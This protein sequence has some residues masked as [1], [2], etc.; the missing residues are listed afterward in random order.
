[1][2]YLQHRGVGTNLVFARS[3][4][5]IPIPRPAFDQRLGIE[6]ACQKCHRDKE[7]AW[8]EAKMKEWYGAIKPHNPS[9][10]RLL[11]SRD[12]A[13]ASDAAALLL[14]PDE[15]HPMAQAAGLGDWME[16]F[17][18]SNA[19]NDSNVIARL[20][21]LSQSADL[22]LKALALA[23]LDVGYSRNADVQVFLADQ[24]R[25]LGPSDEPLRNRWSLAADKLG[26]MFVERGNVQAARDCFQ[27]SLD[28]Q[29]DNVIT[30]S[31]L[32]LAHARN[33]DADEAVR[34][35]VKAI[36]LKPAK[37]ALHFQLA[38]ILVQVQQPAAALRALQEGLKYSP[39]DP[40]AL[41]LLETLQG[42]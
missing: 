24:R 38:Q 40:A 10:T 12:L 13:A 34:W 14:M 2:P 33:G 17:L 8:Q 21:R 3:D 19:P 39:D 20:T 6:N 23:A 4:H 22:D 7:L 35:L 30:L 25:R 27:K 26:S 16:R 15:N 31:H 36:Q 37:A 9:I 11:K 5:S 1:M 42:K 29:P 41:E 32:A 28:V 18:A